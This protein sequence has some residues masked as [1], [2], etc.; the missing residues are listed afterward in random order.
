MPLLPFWSS[1]ILFRFC[2]GKCR[3]WIE[4][5]YV[6]LHRWRLMLV[7]K[8]HFCKRNVSEPSIHF[9]PSGFRTFHRSSS[10]TPRL[11][12]TVLRDASCWEHGE[13]SASSKN[14]QDAHV[15]A[16]C[17]ICEAQIPLKYLSCCSK[18][19]DKA[20]FLTTKCRKFWTDRDQKLANLR[21]KSDSNF[22]SHYLIARM[23]QLECTNYHTQTRTECPTSHFSS[24]C[25]RATSR[26]LCTFNVWL[27]RC[28]PCVTREPLCKQTSNDSNVQNF[29]EFTS[30]PPFKHPK[31]SCVEVY[32]RPAHCPLNLKNWPGKNVTCDTH[33]F[34]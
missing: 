31:R 24:G 4:I 25:Y 33:L 23:G 13:S 32:P 15:V 5:E 6:E 17:G 22:L 21:R 14:P 30:H 12:K 28:E 18:E 26:V 29:D 11:V 19:L 8:W 10:G 16:C 2:H 27:E 7:W 1:L 34:F 9:T 3:R 20:T